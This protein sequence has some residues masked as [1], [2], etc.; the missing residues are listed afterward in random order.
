[1]EVH[2]FPVSRSPISI[3]HRNL[4]KDLELLHDYKDKKISSH[5]CDVTEISPYQFMSTYLQRGPTLPEYAPAH[6][7]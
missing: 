5:I 2:G 7:R 3:S 4:S 6:E 1:M